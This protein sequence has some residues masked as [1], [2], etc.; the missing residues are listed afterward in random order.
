M[1]TPATII[2]AIRTKKLIEKIDASDAGALV[3]CTVLVVA[4]ST[5]VLPGTVVV[6]AGTV[7]VDEG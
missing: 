4:G 5:V 2:S 6:L 7:V 3:G 1:K